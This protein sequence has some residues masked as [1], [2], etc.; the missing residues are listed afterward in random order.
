MTGGRAASL[1][2]LAA[3]AACGPVAL[4]E[5]ERS[6]LEDARLA[7]APRTTVAL[8]VGTGLGG[9]GTTGF[10]RVSVDLSGD[11]LMGRDPSQV[12]DRCVR[13]RSGRPPRQPLA[14]QPGWAG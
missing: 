7:A 11:Y 13:R 10:G 9:G 1:G 6:C 14:D 2:L 4:E 8:G 3:L 12:Y 5:A